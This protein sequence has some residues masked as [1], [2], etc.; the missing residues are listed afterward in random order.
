MITRPITPALNGHFSTPAFRQP[1]RYLSDNDLYSK[2][3]LTKQDLLALLFIAGLDLLV[4]F[5]LA[6]LIF[7]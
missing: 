7:S 2:P 1:K 5:G 4:L 6:R 3:P